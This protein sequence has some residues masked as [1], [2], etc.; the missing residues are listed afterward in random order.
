MLRGSA[1]VLNDG[2]SVV[3]V[4]SEASVTTL[5]L[6]AGDEAVD[7]FD[8]PQAASMPVMHTEAAIET[9]TRLRVTVPILFWASGL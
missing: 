6:D 7:D 4:K 3:N 5:E 1:S 9:H 8:E 2:S